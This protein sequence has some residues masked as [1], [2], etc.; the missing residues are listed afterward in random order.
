MGR[1]EIDHGCYLED[2][3]RFF[4]NLGCK[5]AYNLDGGS[6]VHMWYNGEEIGKPND[7]KPLTDIIYIN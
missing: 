5:E 7:D 1:N 2:M 6:S 3:A 4:A